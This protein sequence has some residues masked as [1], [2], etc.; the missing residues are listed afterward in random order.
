MLCFVLHIRRGSGRLSALTPSPAPEPVR[1]RLSSIRTPPAGVDAGPGRAGAAKQQAQPPQRAQQA[2]R[3]LH[4]RQ[5]WNEHDGR[6]GRDGQRQ[7]EQEGQEGQ[8]G[9]QAQHSD[10]HPS[11]HAAAPT[12]AGLLSCVVSFS[13]SRR[14]VRPR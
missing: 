2:R 10:E 9:G 3:H 8:C 4:R 1:A 5:S 6:E 12:P 13:R 14:S 7:E 11:Q